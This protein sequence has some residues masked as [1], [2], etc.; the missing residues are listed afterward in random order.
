MLKSGL[1][2]YVKVPNY[3]KVWVCEGWGHYWGKGVCWVQGAP[4]VYRGPGRVS[5]PLTSISHSL[6]ANNTIVFEQ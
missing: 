1:E 6:V 3:R 2:M 4:H 5:G